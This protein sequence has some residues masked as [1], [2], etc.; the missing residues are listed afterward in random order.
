MISIEQW[1]A[2][3]GCFCPRANKT[4]A[5]INS[6]VI[7]RGVVLVS[8][9]VFIALSLCLI[10]CGDIESNP[11]PE[12]I[13]KQ[14]ND[15]SILMTTQFGELKASISGLQ[16]SVTDIQSTVTTL[17]DSLRDLKDKVGVLEDKQSAMQLDIDKND[18]GVGE[19]NDRLAKL[20]ELIERQEQ[21]S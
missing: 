13:E 8:S 21:Y 2:K 11:G 14:L 6:I 12:G 1:R 17:S 10:L 20:G 15:L 19:I 16:T 9:R 4:T 18:H 5:K 3:V 7:S